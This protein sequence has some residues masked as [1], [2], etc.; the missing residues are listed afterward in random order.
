MT[1][2]RDSQDELD[3]KVARLKRARARE[4]SLWRTVTHAGTL[5]WMLVLPMVLGGFLGHHFFKQHGHPW[6]AIA[7][8]VLGLVVGGYGVWRSVQRSLEQEDNG[9]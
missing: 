3:R 5:G 7:G 1:A 6:P 9:A 8:V 4:S 2:W